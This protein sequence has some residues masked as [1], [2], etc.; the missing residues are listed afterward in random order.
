MAASSSEVPGPGV[1]ESKISLELDALPA[2]RSPA[3]TRLMNVMNLQIPMSRL[4][5]PSRPSP[6]RLPTS[7]RLPSKEPQSQLDQARFKMD[8]T[9]L[10]T[11]RDVH[12]QF[13]SAETD[14][15]FICP[16]Q[17][18]RKDCRTKTMQ[19]IPASATAPSNGEVG[20]LVPCSGRAL[21]RGQTGDLISP[22]NRPLSRGPGDPTLS[23][24]R[25]LSRGPA[26]D[27]PGFADGGAGHSATVHIGRPEGPRPSSRAGT[28]SRGKA[29]LAA[30]G[31][32]SAASSS[33]R[34]EDCDALDSKADVK[35]GTALVD[36]AD[37]DADE[38][39]HDQVKEG[40]SSEWKI[41]LARRATAKVATDAPAP[42]LLGNLRSEESV[43]ENEDV[44]KS[45][46]APLSRPWSPGSRFPSKC[47][48]GSRC[49][50]KGST[51]SKTL[52][53]KTSHLIDDDVS[54]EQLQSFIE[55]LFGEYSR[56]RDSAGRPLMDNNGLRQFFLAFVPGK[57]NNAVKASA[58]ACF[59]DE[60]ERQ[61][62]MHFSFDLSKKDARRGLS[63][64]MFYII[65][66]QVMP[67]GFSFEVGRQRFAEFNGNAREMKEALSPLLATA[68]A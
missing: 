7:A 47:S 20:D 18:A 55:Q 21:T 50:S 35:D 26:V 44:T 51:T 17:K 46:S 28:C 6:R 9:K 34:L 30:A 5:S 22:S 58:D 43:E 48:K 13:E 4:A 64:R 67:S 12:G 62:N 31:P 19:S 42:V 2:L 3:R 16:A 68:G 59:D 65:L 10:P 57:E 14:S 37:D 53:K 54:D 40:E 56:L 33:K 24:D 60:I 36:D 52:K 15:H 63:Y 8:G 45:S 27:D 66:N 25:P 23:F 11:L 49:V 39:S 41:C 1:A 61:T 38:C 32:T 29:A